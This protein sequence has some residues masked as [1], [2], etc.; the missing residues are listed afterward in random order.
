M[1]EPLIECRRQAFV[2]ADKSGDGFTGEFV[3]LDALFHFASPLGWAIMLKRRLAYGF[4]DRAELD[5]R[6]CS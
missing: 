5:K 4:C 6:L 2:E 1:A 3:G